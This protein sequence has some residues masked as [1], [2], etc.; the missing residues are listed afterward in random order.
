MSSATAV[1]ACAIC[2]KPVSLESAKAD[3]NGQTVHEKCY[4]L[5]LRRKQGPPGRTAGDARNRLMPWTHC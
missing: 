4:V 2:G 3:E 5:K 1:P